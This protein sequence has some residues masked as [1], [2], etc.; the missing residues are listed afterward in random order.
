MIIV[1]SM[2]NCPKCSMIKTKLKQE[3]IDFSD[4]YRIKV[5]KKNLISRKKLNRAAWRKEF[6]MK[7]YVKRKITVKRPIPKFAKISFSK[8]QNQ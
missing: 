3:N 4:R 1:Y 7:L 8:S 5:L 6:L 2:Q